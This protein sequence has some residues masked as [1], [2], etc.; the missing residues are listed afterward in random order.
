VK[1]LYNPQLRR[2][3]HS[4]GQLVLLGN[5]GLSHQQA[6]GLT[7]RALVA[8]SVSLHGTADTW[9]MWDSPVHQLLSVQACTLCSMVY[10]ANPSYPKC[11]AD[12]ESLRMVVVGHAAATSPD[13]RNQR[14]Q[15]SRAWQ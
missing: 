8:R 2:W 13:T 15:V 11:W 1:E 6:M 5:M 12:D 10:W 3:L 9:G 7:Q 14:F 4:T